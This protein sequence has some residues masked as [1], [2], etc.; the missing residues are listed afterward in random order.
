MEL[1]FFYIFAGVAIVSAVMVVTNKNVLHATL[2]LILT[3]FCVAAIYILLQAEFLA[4]IQV[5]LYV[6]AIMALFVFTI[7][8]INVMQ[9]QFLRQFHGQ[10]PLAAVLVAALLLE[11]LFLLFSDFRGN[12][13][14]LPETPPETAGKAGLGMLSYL[15]LTDYLLLFEVASIL[16]LAALIG[17]V[18]LARGGIATAG[19][20]R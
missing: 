11:T 6:G 13:P 14:L 2:F 8:L 15:L 5:L 20:R 4:A 7:L 18:V 1:L 16:L 12:F 10:R 9:A 3:F 17:A 19:G